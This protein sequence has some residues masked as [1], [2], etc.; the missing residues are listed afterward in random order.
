[1][2]LQD[3]YKSDNHHLYHHCFGYSYYCGHLQQVPMR[4]GLLVYWSLGSRFLDP[5]WLGLQWMRYAVIDNGPYAYFRLMK[6]FSML[7]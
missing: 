7:T 6:E 4:N 5:A 1:M 3:G 2:K